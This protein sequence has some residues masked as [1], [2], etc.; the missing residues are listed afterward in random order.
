MQAIQLPKGGAADSGNPHSF[1]MSGTEISYVRDFDVQVAQNA[2]AADPD[3][4][5]LFEGAILDVKVI[6]VT[7][8]ITV[9]EVKAATG[10]LAKLTGK[11]LGPHPDAW[12]LWWKT[13]GSKSEHGPATS[14]PK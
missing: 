5:V 6:G 12:A 7:E 3:V 13:E 10:S 1:I 11:N 8:E 2:F 14:T 9:A 4:G